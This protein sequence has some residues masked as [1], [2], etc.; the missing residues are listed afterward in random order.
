MIFLKSIL[1]VLLFACPEIMSLAVIQDTYSIV[2][3][4][5]GEDV[6]DYLEYSIAQARLFNRN[7]NIFLLFNSIACEKKQTFFNNL[8]KIYDVH[9]IACE[10]LT[11]S[12]SHKK[13]ESLCIQ[14]SVSGFWR[15]TT[16]RFFYIDEFMKQY[17]LNDVFQVECD[18]MLY[19]NLENYLALLHTYYTDIASPFQNDYLACVS[20]VYLSNPAAIE[21]FA[22]FIPNQLKGQLFEPDMYLLASYRNYN[23]DKVNNLPTISKDLM[24]RSILKNARGEIAPEPW[25]YWNRIEEWDSIFDND[26]IGSYLQDGYWKANQAYFNPDVYQFIWDV[27]FEGRRIPYLCYD[28]FKYRI[29]TLHVASKKDFSQYLSQ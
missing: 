25:R 6:P 12:A 27:D 15:L 8:K 2:F 16:E 26:G 20:F 14:R 7:C 9:L 29:N 21:K 1:G 10:T 4:Y 24:W 13:F 28:K 11:Q 22:N 19:I 5:L 23:P 3:V 17:Q 18:V